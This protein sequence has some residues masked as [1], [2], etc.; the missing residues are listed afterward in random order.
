MANSIERDHRTAT[1]AGLGLRRHPSA[2]GRHPDDR[3]RDGAVSLTACARPHSGQKPS[4]LMVSKS[5]GR[6]A[7]TR[8]PASPFRPRPF[9]ARSDRRR[10]SPLRVDPSGWDCRRGGRRSRRAHW[11]WTAATNFRARWAGCSI[12]ASA[13]EESKATDELALFRFAHAFDLVG[14]D[15]EFGFADAAGAQQSGLFLRPGV[16]VGVMKRSRRH[17]WSLGRSYS[18]VD[19]DANSQS[20][21]R[22]PRQQLP[23]GGLAERA[24]VF[25]RFGSSTSNASDP[26]AHRPRRETADAAL[27]GRAWPGDRRLARAVEHGEERALAASATPVAASRIGASAVEPPR[28]R[29]G[30]AVRPIAPCPTAGRNSSIVQ[31]RSR[32]MRRARAASARHRQAASRRSRRSRRLP[33]RVST[34][35]RSSDT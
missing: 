24:A 33:S 14:D 13:A 21:P 10:R 23:P 19:P 17:G 20:P 1:G 16:E 6:S 8:P 30:R 32:A 11:R 31:H 34:L 18:A 35:P 28:D 27:D 4:S 7:R 26:S 22:Q 3:Q 15:H 2:V 12:S 5:T 29:P 9:G 25:R